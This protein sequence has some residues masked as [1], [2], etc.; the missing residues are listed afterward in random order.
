M[1]G[2]KT[3]VVMKNGVETQKLNTLT[4]AKNLADAE[5]VEVF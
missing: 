4:A 2:K 5:G 3:Y 1:A